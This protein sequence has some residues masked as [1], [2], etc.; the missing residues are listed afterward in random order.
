MNPQYPQGMPMLHFMVFSLS[1][2]DL[3]THIYSISNMSVLK[4]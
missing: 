4:R 3:Q 2:S 1:F